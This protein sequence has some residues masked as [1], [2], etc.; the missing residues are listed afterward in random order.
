MPIY[1]L[2]CDKCDNIVESDLIKFTE[3]DKFKEDNAKC[4]KCKKGNMIQQ[5]GTPAFKGDGHFYD[6][7]GKV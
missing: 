2:K 1:E 3:L 6:P 5:L 4:K 7:K